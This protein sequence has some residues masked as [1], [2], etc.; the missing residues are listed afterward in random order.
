M[1]ETVREVI[2]RL[3]DLALKLK[4]ENNSL[5]RI[6]EQNNEEKTLLIA[7]LQKALAEK[8]AALA[9]D[10]RQESQIALEMAEINFQK[11][12]L[13]EQAVV[14]EDFKKQMVES[15][16]EQVELENVINQVLDEIA[17]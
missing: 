2:Q 16:T 1:K 13:E 10:E 4:N 15:D 8:E 9:N 6:I 5:K 17:K 3:I 14:I 11:K 12:L 7:D